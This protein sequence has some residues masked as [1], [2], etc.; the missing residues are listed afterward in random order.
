VRQPGLWSLLDPLVDQA[1]ALG[2]DERRGLIDQ[3]IEQ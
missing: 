3:W 2:L 1:A